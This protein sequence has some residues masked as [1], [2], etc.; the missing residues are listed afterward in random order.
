LSELTLNLQTVVPQFTEILNIQNPQGLS[1]AI[2]AFLIVIFFAGAAFAMREFSVSRASVN[3][4]EKLLAG[5][6][7]E[8]LAHRRREFKERAERETKNGKLWREFDESLVLVERSARLFNTIDASHFFNTY[9]LARG[10]TDN[11]LLAAMPGILTAIGVVGTFAGLQMGLASLSASVTGV[12]G[13]GMTDE[14]TAL[15]EGIF[16][17]IAGASVAFMTS[18][19]GVFLSVSFNFYEKILERLIRSRINALQNRID[20]LYPRI[21]AEQSLVNI[22]ESS[23]HSKETLAGLDEKIG[24]RLQEAMTKAADSMKTSISESLR[25]VLGPAVE[26]LV[27]N[28]HHGSEKALDGLMSEFLSKIGSA[29]EGQRK[30][31]VDTASAVQV[32][33]REI[34]QGVEGLIGKLDAFLGRQEVLTGSFEKLAASNETASIELRGASSSLRDGASTMS[35][36]ARALSDSNDLLAD[37]VSRA[38]EQL[39]DSARMLTGINAA[40][41]SSIERLE[42]IYGTISELDERLKNVSSQTGSDMQKIQE[43]TSKVLELFKEQMNVFEGRMTKFSE[44]QEKALERTTATVAE[45]SLGVSGQVDALLAKVATTLQSNLESADTFRGIASANSNAATQLASVASAIADSANNL[46]GHNAGIVNATGLLN[47]TTSAAAG[48]IDEAARTM[49]I[50]ADS[51]Q[52]STDH[53]NQLA[54]KIQEVAGQLVTVGERADQGLTKVNEHFDRVSESMKAHIKELE[55]QLANLLSDYSLQVRTQTTERLNV[56]NSQTQEYAGA[57]TD[58]VQA[59]AGV[60]D[61]I[62]RSQQGKEGRN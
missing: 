25:E 52:N 31:L 53:V 57:M 44:H 17:M 38:S 54:S 34:N 47:E 35:L 59:L 51:Q 10:L 43:N 13:V 60:V 15:K 37:A 50:V 22:E 26:K 40:H 6:D 23:L 3:E 49:A 5:A 33:S 29:G 32:A 7:R 56:W 11:R 41:Q 48:K 1:A 4:I 28:A 2:V 9:S 42:H 19:W 55:G 8:N 36:Q 21:T 16:A 39:S 18:L 27:D 12:S 58:A 45:A 61:E 30:A 46:A 24:H 14:V 62:E 20:F